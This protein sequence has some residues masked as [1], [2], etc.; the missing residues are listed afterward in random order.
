MSTGTGIFLSGLIIGLV[1]LYGQT[2]DRW[3]WRTITKNSVFVILSLSFLIYQFLS[4][5]KMFKVDFSVKGFFVGLVLWIGIFIISFLPMS[6][7]SS[8][9]TDFLDKSF[10]YDDD[11]N[12]R[13]IYKI[14]FWGSLILVLFNNFYFY[15]SIINCTND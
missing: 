4:D 14:F 15:Y 11:G 2:K 12:E 9:Y 5:W 1:M 6:F 8:I 10:E 3:D 13:L 7:I